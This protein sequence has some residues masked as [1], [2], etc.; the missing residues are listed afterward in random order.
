M[1]KIALLALVVAIP[2]SLAGCQPIEDFGRGFGEAYKEAKDAE[3]AK[4]LEEADQKL[5]KEAQNLESFP[6][7]ESEVGNE[8]LATEKDEEWQRESELIDVM[9]DSLYELQDENIEGYMSYFSLTPE[10]YEYN[11]Q[12]N[13]QLAEKYDTAYFL[14]DV[15]VLESTSTTA[16]VQVTQTTTRIGGAEDFQ[17]NKGVF[18]HYMIKEDGEWKFSKSEIVSVVPIQ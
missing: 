12:L 7:L 6:T 1:K 14:E 5:V 16:K 18:I 4:R 2:L 11:L 15:K 3:Q 8:Q 9:Y 17:D 10:N 13:K